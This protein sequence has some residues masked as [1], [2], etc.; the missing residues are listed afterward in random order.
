M[1][2]YVYRGIY[3]ARWHC[4]TIAYIYKMI[5]TLSKLII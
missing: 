1:S 4:L 3:Y 5:V 2:V